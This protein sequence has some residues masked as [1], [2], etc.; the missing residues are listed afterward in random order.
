MPF[1]V[2]FAHGLIG[3]YTCL[4]NEHFL[5]LFS[6]S[7]QTCNR[8]QNCMVNFYNAI[9]YV[10]LEDNR[11]QFMLTLQKQVGTYTIKYSLL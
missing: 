6:S 10:K 4:K 1:V 2:G 9:Y 8:I 11:Y 5:C 7:E 3:S